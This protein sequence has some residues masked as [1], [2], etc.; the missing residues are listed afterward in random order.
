[1]H[2]KGHC[3]E[4]YREMYP[5]RPEDKPPRPDPRT[6][7]IGAFP[8][9][10]DWSAVRNAAEPVSGE[11]NRPAQDLASMPEPSAPNCEPQQDPSWSFHRSEPAAPEP[12]NPEDTGTFYGSE[13]AAEPQKAEDTGVFYG[14]PDAPVGQIPDYGW[15]APPVVP[16]EEPI[17]MNRRI[18]TMCAVIAVLI[19]LLCVYC[20]GS[21]VLHGALGADL[22]P[23]RPVTVNLKMQEKPELSPDDENVTADGEY[24]VRGVAEMVTA[25]I[26]EV[27]TFHDA[28]RSTSALEGSGSGIIIS[29]DGYIITNA[30]VVQGEAFGVMLDDSEEML[31]AEL[32][33]SD[34]KTDL[35]VLKI[36]KN[37]LTPA[38]LGNSDETYVGEN[39]VAIG[40]PAGLKNTVTRGIVSAIGRQMRAESNNFRME[41]IQTDAAIS[42]GNS[43]GALVNMYGQVIGITSSKYASMYTSTYEGLGFAITI[44]QALPIVTEL[45]E[46]GYVTGRFR[47]GI[48]LSPA[49]AEMVQ[50]D[51]FNEYGCVIPE[52]LQ[53]GIVISEVSG[54]CDISNTELA[55]GDIILSVEGKKVSSYDDVID[56]L[57]GHK[58][59]DTVTAHC[60]HLDKGKIQYFDITF[61]LE[62]DTS[63]NF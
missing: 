33:G 27:Y 52:E 42:P 60:A 6:D 29:E 26:V 54:D 63:G 37:G 12:Q 55:P 19:F 44:N 16:P 39:V 59:G 17:S 58:G 48:V 32:I 22:I 53:A 61:K 40:N 15:Q 47:V 30:H 24:T 20:I 8:E 41:C 10:P 62:E 34:A 28:S 25:S 7:P 1:M 51:Y 11:Q 3:M 35:A 5:K 23:E 56:A 9:N 45:I 43:G 18:Y 36:Q 2:E 57:D 4:D 31:D 49:S 50:E 13:N 46:N 14:D 38:V 21:D